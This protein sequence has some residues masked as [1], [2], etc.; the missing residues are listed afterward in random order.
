MENDTQ[1]QADTYVPRPTA[2]KE[3][4]VAKLVWGF[5]KTWWPTAVAFLAMGG[6]TAFASVV[7]TQQWYQFAVTAGLSLL[8]VLVVAAHRL[9]YMRRP[10]C[11]HCGGDVAECE[12]RLLLETPRQCMSEIGL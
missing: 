12:R 8:V 2:A 1:T 7:D 3:R 9:S 6:F 4:F 11:R 5:R 10:E